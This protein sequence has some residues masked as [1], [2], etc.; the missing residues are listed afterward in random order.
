MPS[1]SLSPSTIEERLARSGLRPHLDTEG[2]AQVPLD[3]AVHG[4]GVGPTVEDDGVPLFGL[5]EVA[6][7]C[8]GEHALDG[9]AD[10]SAGGVRC[11]ARRQC[12]EA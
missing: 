7:G 5:G 6:D 8:L 1:R 12:A 2:V 9:H 11:T 3:E 10:A 4:A